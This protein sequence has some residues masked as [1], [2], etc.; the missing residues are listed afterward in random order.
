[1]HFSI[2][3]SLTLYMAK[4]LCTTAIASSALV[5]F[6]PWVIRQRKN[7]EIQRNLIDE[8]RKTTLTAVNTHVRTGTIEEFHRKTLYLFL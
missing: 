6:E 1:M 4:K 7:P 3:I 5:K 2:S 8:K